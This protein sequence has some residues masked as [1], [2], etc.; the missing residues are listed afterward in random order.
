MSAPAGTPAAI[1]QRINTEMRALVT[2]PAFSKKLMELGLVTQPMSTTEL[3][4]FFKSEEAKAAQ[5]I[6]QSGAVID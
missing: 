3:V 6:R 4:A 1:V 5:L 2:D